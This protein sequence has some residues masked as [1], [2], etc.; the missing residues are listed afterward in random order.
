M[1][2]FESL[3]H[4]FQINIEGIKLQKEELG[5]RKKFWVEIKNSELHRHEKVFL[6]N[7]ACDGFL[8]MNFLS[9]E[10][11]YETMIKVYYDYS[12]FIQLKS[13]LKLSKENQHSR[14]SIEEDMQTVLYII[15]QV[16]RVILDAEDCMLFLDRFHLR[17][18]CIFI[19]TSSKEVKIAYIPDHP[20]LNTQENKLVVLIE[21]VED[22]LQNSM[23]SNIL[24]DLKDKILVENI[25]ADQIRNLIGKSLRDLK[26][27]YSIE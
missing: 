12:G 2:E 16:I 1:K 15:D 13:Y 11:N 6:S 24:R 7:H 4:E 22:L 10:I 18:D 27:T 26:I 19:N 25:G 14:F 9:N 8:P 5:G 21:S 23:A 3:I 17:A 20:K